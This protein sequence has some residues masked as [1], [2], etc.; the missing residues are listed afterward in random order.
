MECN[1]GEGIKGESASVHLGLEM[2]GSM[3]KFFKVK[4][5]CRIQVRSCGESSE[6]IFIYACSRTAA[7]E[8]IE[9]LRAW[10]PCLHL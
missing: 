2:E 6:G 4:L 1:G 3:V 8:W 7:R 10:E 5:E 9:V